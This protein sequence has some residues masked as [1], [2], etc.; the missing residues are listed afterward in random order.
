MPPD[1]DRRSIDRDLGAMSSDIK[2]LEKG[3]DGLRGDIGK[4]FDKIEEYHQESLTH[5]CVQEEDVADH[6]TRLRSHHERI[7]KIGS[8]VS[9][10][11][12]VTVAIT[13]VISLAIGAVGLALK[14]HK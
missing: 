3:I 11:K 5:V 10:I 13:S 7:Q 9:G 2:N 14:W 12:K 1:D 6:E 4:I 8:E